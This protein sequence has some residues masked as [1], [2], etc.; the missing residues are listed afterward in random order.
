MENGVG[1]NQ[2]TEYVNTALVDHLR[3]T[4]RF[5]KSFLSKWAKGGQDQ[6]KGGTEATDW[7]D[8]A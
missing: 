5:P 8:T 7:T 4:N 1:R 3:N 6:P 2:T